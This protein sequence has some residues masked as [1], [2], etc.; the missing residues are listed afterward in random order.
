MLFTDFHGGKTVTSREAHTSVISSANA[1]V[2]EP[3]WRYML[4][5][6]VN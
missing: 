3:V 5:E 1:R 6:K 4:T 2:F